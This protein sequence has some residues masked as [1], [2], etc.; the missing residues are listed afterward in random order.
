[1]GIPKISFGLFGAMALSA[2]FLA[3]SAVQAGDIV[4][5]V[6]EPV[7]SSVYSG[8][9]NLRGWVVGSSGIAKVELH[10]DG[11]FLTNVPAGGFRSDV[12]Q[13]YPSYP[14]SNNAGFSMA[15]NYSNLSVGPHLIRV[16]A[17]DQAGASRDASVNF[18]VTR[19][20]NPY[21]A[22]PAKISLGG[23][24]STL[25]TR[26]ISLKNVSAD[27]KNYD[28]RLDWRSEVQGFVITQATPTGGPPGTNY[29]GGYH[30]V[31]SQTSNSCAFP[32]NQQTTS[33]L[34]LTQAG[35]Q[36]TGTESN[37]LPVSG[38]VDS[39]GNFSLLSNRQSQTSGNCR[40]ESYFKYQGSFPS[41]TT[42]ISIYFEYFGSCPYSNCT[43]NF[44][45][46][47]NK[48]NTQAS[49]HQA[50]NNAHSSIGDGVQS[51]LEAAKAF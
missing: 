5:T 17:I 26:S 21:I 36:L 22:D 49:P 4:L 27:G 7:S 45:G 19:F 29:S 16:R 34:Q 39:S 18:N 47:I 6:E 43:A 46:S 50:L 38:T 30:S 11:V 25:D 37:T 9:S 15:F 33:D 10:V 2:N 28:L 44:Q 3:A 13:Q 23:A 51:V 40:G 24:S 14:N 42:A 48:V 12:G 41:Q 35:T 32:V 31:V 20:D 8:V 1:M